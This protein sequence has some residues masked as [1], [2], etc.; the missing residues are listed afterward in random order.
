MTTVFG[1]NLDLGNSWCR[2][3]AP[4]L[5]CTPGTFPSGPTSCTVSMLHP[6]SGKYHLHK[7]TETKR[8]SA[9]ENVCTSPRDHVTHVISVKPTLNNGSSN[10]HVHDCTFRPLSLAGLKIP[11]LGGGKETYSDCMGCEHGQN[12]LQLQVLQ[13]GSHFLE[14][15]S[16]ISCF[17]GAFTRISFAT[18]EFELQTDRSETSFPLWR[19]EF[20]ANSLDLERFIPNSRS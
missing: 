11:V 12:I 2:K 5:V 14:L 4:S 17:W 18:F 7:T 8:D 15:V 13:H 3:S 16:G 9:P 10:R 1:T 6:E 20:C 19:E